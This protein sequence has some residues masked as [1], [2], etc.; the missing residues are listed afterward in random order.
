MSITWTAA[1]QILVILAER[2]NTVP[3]NVN[4]V[5]TVRRSPG[6]RME[7]GL[8]VMLGVAVLLLRAALGLYLSGVSRSKDALS[9][10]FRAVAETCVAILAFWAV[11][12]NLIRHCPRGICPLIAAWDPPIFFS[13]AVCLAAAALAIAP[14]LERAKAN[15]SLIGAAFIAGFVIP[16]CWRL[17]HSHWLAGHGFVDIA[18]SSF[19][20]FSAGI[21]GAVGAYAVGPRT[22]KYNRDGSTNVLLGHSATLT[23]FA[24]L[25]ILS[26]WIPYVVGA[27]WLHSPATA[28]AAILNTLLAGAAAGTMAMIYSQ[29]RYRK[30][31]VML[32]YAGLLGGL[33]AVTGAAGHLLP[34]WAAFIGAM[35]GILVPWLEVRLELFWK[36]DDP[37]GFIAICVGGGAWGTLATAIFANDSSMNGL[38]RLGIQAV[39][40]VAIGTVSFISFGLLLLLL[41]V[42]LGIRVSESQEREGLDLSQHDSNAYPDF[43]QTMIKSYDLRQM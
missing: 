21:M 10:L 25:L 37:S 7:I 33:V 35:A 1:E 6:E 5:E 40:L 26:L 11:G 12:A 41:R 22:G 2:T 39:G 36:I 9:A 8:W 13:A 27:E 23:S 38:H 15:V 30:L 3:L 31:D 19:I 16:F 17:A 24:I 29:L 42:T 34:P 20:H 14:M 28:S 32:I 18:G 43:Q 4:G